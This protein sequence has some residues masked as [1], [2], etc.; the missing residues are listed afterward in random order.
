MFLELD[1]RGQYPAKTTLAFNFFSTL[2][3]LTAARKGNFDFLLLPRAYNRGKKLY[4]FGKLSFCRSTHLP[5]LL[6]VGCLLSICRVF[7]QKDIRVQISIW[8]ER[9]LFLFVYKSRQKNREGW[10]LWTKYAVIIC[11]FARIP[12]WHHPSGTLK[13][14]PVAQ[15]HHPEPPKICHQY[16][17]KSINAPPS[18]FDFKTSTPAT[19]N[20]AAP[21]NFLPQIWNFG[22]SPAF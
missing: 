1:L 20:N 11:L 19:D 22:F 13:G 17:P 5:Q 10:L 8:R 21:P 6:C 12:E 15:C 18:L 7:E 2:S 14:L 9:N 4:L 3:L 16:P